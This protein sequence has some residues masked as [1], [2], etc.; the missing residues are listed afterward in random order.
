MKISL[1]SIEGFPESC[2]AAAC[3]RIGKKVLHIDPNEYYGGAWA[4]FG[5]EALNALLDGKEQSPERQNEE[6]QNGSYKWHLPTTGNGNE[7]EIIPDENQDQQDTWTIEKIMKQSRRFNLDLCPRILYSTGELV[8]LLISSNIC[9]YA[10]FR[11][12]D[13]VCTVF[14]NKVL[15]VPCSRSD[16]FNTKDLNMVEKRLLMKFFTSCMTFNEDP[17]SSPGQASPTAL[18]QRPIDDNT[19]L[20]MYNDKTFSEYINSQ[21]LTD[22]I[23]QC[24]M[25]AIAMVTRD[26]TFEEGMHQTRKF[27]QSLGRYS[28]TPFIFP[29]YGCGEIPQCFCRLSAV[30]GGVYCLKRAIT[31]IRWSGETGSQPPSQQGISIEV[32]G[33]KITA[34]YLIVSPGNIP[35]SLR[36]TK[37]SLQTT[38][39]R[40]IFITTASIT[41]QLETMEQRS[42]GGV[43][44][45]R[46]LSPDGHREAM[47][48]QLAHQ[49]GTCPQN[50]CKICHFY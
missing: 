13:N 24:L 23:K 43:T 38:L 41:N 22:K 2:V 9:R 40:A 7:D 11:A 48:I 29:M 27:L 14:E 19:L 46:L 20:E 4:S 17:N 10:E 36:S 44:I 39:S 26:T 30:F 35:S 47:I 6:I 50:L 33:Q 5:L 12:I 49:S 28:N 31:D 3:S 25:Q 1:F 34:Q 32:E 15:A 16:I 21:Q 37:V 18:N 8:Q 45:L 42:G